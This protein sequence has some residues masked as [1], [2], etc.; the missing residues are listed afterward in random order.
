MNAKVWTGFSKRINSTKQPTS[1]SDLTVNLKDGTSIT[2]PTFQCS[3]VGSNVNYLYISDW[4]RYYFVTDAVQVTKDMVE[5]HCDVDP[6]ASGKTY[7]GNTKA[8]ITRTS[9][10][11]NLLVT[12]PRNSPTFKYDEK[13]TSILDLTQHGFSTSGTYIVGLVTD[14]GLNYY[15]M[16]SSKLASLCSALFNTSFLPSLINSFYDLKNILVSCIWVPF[17]PTGVGL[18]VA[19]SVGGEALLDQNQQVVTAKRIA[20]RYVSYSSGAVTVGYPNDNNYNVDNYLDAA[21]YTTGSLY[22]PFVGVVPFDCDI[23]FNDKTLTLLMILD[24]YTGDIVYYLVDSSSNPV[25]T[26][27]G[28]CATSVPIAGQ[29][30][31]P[32]GAIPGALSIVGGAAGII[33]G[34][35]VGN[36]GAVAGGVGALASTSVGVQNSLSFHTQVNGKIS[37]G[38]GSQLPL[39]AAAIIRTRRPCETAIES[40]WQ[41]DCGW[42]QHKDQQISSLSGY[43]Q[44]TDASVDCPFTE[45]EKQSINSYLNSGFYYE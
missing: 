21:P 7:I 19:L 35:A 38:V 44:C 39:V 8:N 22:L 1:G 31:A 41:A 15:A 25:A 10:S 26:Y 16:D 34:L 32:G 23:F 27:Q 11:V 4:G 14:A 12:D 9:S 20:T 40:A 17:T 45:G 24:Q 43:I 42:E 18:D 2:H 37:S 6:L 30:T 5:L 28:N 13:Y 29:T 3:T 33:G 36:L